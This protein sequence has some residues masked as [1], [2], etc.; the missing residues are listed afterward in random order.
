MKTKKRILIF[1]KLSWKLMKPANLILMIYKDGDENI[2]I[3]KR[4][5]LR[6]FKNPVVIQNVVIVFEI[7]PAD[8]FQEN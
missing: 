2:Y 8:S 1:L 4:I 7:N 3:H 6:N 5:R